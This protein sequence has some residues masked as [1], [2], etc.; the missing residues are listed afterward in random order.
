MD[1][2]RGD[3]VGLV[4]S[5]GRYEVVARLGEG[6]MGSV[7]RVLDANI[8]AD[9][10]VKVPRRALLDD[11]EFASRFAREIR[12]LVRLAHPNIVRVSDVGEHDGLP[13][14][15]MQ[16]LPGGS[17][18]DRLARDASGRPAPGDARAITGWLGPVAAALDFVHAQGYIHRDVKPGNIL[19]D[20]HGHA[21]LSDF[22]VAKVI[23]SAEPA[24][25]GRRAA[26]T[27]TGMVLGTPEY[28]APELIMGRDVDGRIDQY[29]LAVTVYEVLCGRR[30]FEAQTGTAVLVMQ[31]NTPPPPIAGPG[32]AVSRAVEQVVMKGLAKDPADRFPTCA[33]FAR[34]FEAAASREAEPAAARGRVACPTCRR[35]LVLPTPPGGP[36]ALRGKAFAC[37]A[38]KARLRFGDDG[39]TLFLADGDASGGSPRTELIAVPAD[40]G[41]RRFSAPE[42]AAVGAGAV[43]GPT[44]RGLPATRIE[45]APRRNS[46]AT[47][48]EPSPAA[49]GDREGVPEAVDEDAAAARHLP[50]AW[51][52]GGVAALVLMAVTVVVI[53]GG[54]AGSGTIRIVLDAPDGPLSLTLDGEP[55]E[56]ATLAGDKTLAPGRHV[57]AASGRGVEDFRQEFEVRRGA[58]PALRARVLPAPPK[59][60]ESVAPAP[61]PALTAV[62]GPMLAGGMPAMNAGTPAMPG[63]PQPNP[64]AGRGNGP[65]A[66][67]PAPPDAF[68]LATKVGAD[69]PDPA[70]VGE[71]GAG[72]GQVMGGITLD[73]VMV[74]PEKY[75]GKVIVPAGRH[76]V[77]NTLA[78]PGGVTLVVYTPKVRYPNPRAAAD[79]AVDPGLARMIRRE[80][81][82]NRLATGAQ[83]K[84]EA[85]P[86]VRVARGSGGG[87]EFVAE[88]TRIEYVCM[89][90]FEAIA[91]R[92]Y[93]RAFGCLT[94]TP[95]GAR[96]GPGDGKDWSD[97]I[98][99]IALGNIRKAW[100][101][102]KVYMMTQQANSVQD[103]AMKGAAVAGAQQQ[104]AQASM[105]RRL[106]GN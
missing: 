104:A 65:V 40:T 53:A 57:L 74:H 90:N 106:I 86:T 73:E 69:V 60:A 98:G 46:P 16:Y 1:P 50:I 4:L 7:Y 9:V 10:V 42:V 105:L 43:D 58:N 45:A 24:G 67:A 5:N 48:I 54:G 95:E 87:R 75:L 72:D 31:A 49:A 21:F 51:I 30:P 68:Q 97:R 63:S 39:R 85:I 38:C 93:G 18:E 11:P 29:A 20:A 62:M 102:Q 99:G 27:G 91:D 70:P 15:V 12:S 78:G 13:F 82:Q 19:F 77:E 103:F 34:A 35:G 56:R 76:R 88:I 22:G 44:G 59:L 66:P 8:E 80:M 81:V 14:A 96:F 28:M 47:M 61:A 2:A 71:A 55:I 3:W 25:P 101:T 36:E 17:L 84:Y 6:G 79:L 52:A 32:V 94:V 37:P 23:A 64:A 33:E 92:R 26:N 41:T 100:N 83:M 89:W